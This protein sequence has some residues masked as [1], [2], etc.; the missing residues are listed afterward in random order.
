VTGLAAYGLRCEFLVTPLGI[1][2]PVPRLS[3][4]MRSE[5]RGDRPTA[6]RVTVTRLSAG[7]EPAEECLDSGWQ[8]AD[9][10]EA[11]YAGAPLRS[12]T[13]YAWHVRLR[14]GAGADGPAADSWFETGLLHPGEWQAQWI[15]RDPES[16]PPA[17]PPTDHDI[18]GDGLLGFLNRRLPPCGYLRRSFTLPA[19]PVRAR[20]LI[21]ARGLYEAR[22]NGQRA[23]DAELA[24]G[25]TDYR[26]RI[27]YQCYDVTGLLRA[28]PN[29]LGA[30]LGDGWYSGRVGPGAR[31]LGEHY[32]TR[33]ELLCQLHVDL[34]GGGPEVICSDGQWH[35]ATGP[36][37]SADL[38][39][40]ECYDARRELDGWDR[41]GYAAPGW[42]P[43]LV[44]GPDTA[45]LTASSDEPVRV[46][47][48]LAPRA[49][50]RQPDG[51]F[52]ADLGQNMVGRV[53]L[54]IRGARRGDR[55]VLRHGEMLAAD[56]RLYTANLRLAAATDT[57]I[58]AG[59]DA[60][61]FEP[62]FTV[63]GFRYVEITGCRAAPAPGDL[64]GLV[65]HSDVP[66]AGE[67]QTSDDTVNALLSNIWW[68]QRG[69]SVSVPTDCP[70]RDE[71]LGWLADAQ[72]FLPTA[73]RNADVAAFFARWMR[74]VI[75]SRLPGGAFPDVAP[76]LVFERT[77]APGWGDAGVIIPWT[78]WRTY[79]DRRVL[80]RS[81]DAMAGW[82]DYVHA[83]NPDLIWRHRTGNHYGDWLQAGAQTPREVLATAYFARSAGL[84]ASAAQVLGRDEQARQYGHLAARITA[85]F[86]A[87][88]VFPD[89][90][91]AGETQTSYLL[92]LGFGLL[93]PELADAAAARLAAD[94]EAR[95]FR[96]TTGF[97]G[98]ALLCPVLT[99]HGRADL[100]YALLHQDGYPSWNYSIRHGATTIWERWDG[101]TDER[102]F[103][104]VAMNSFNHY[105]L[106]SVGDWLF[107]SAG[108]IGQAA[109]SAG[110]REVV[111]SP[112]PGGR[113]TWARAWQETPR[114]RITCAWRIADGQ[115]GLQVSIPPGATARVRVPTADPATVREGGVPVA[116]APGL[117]VAGTSDR[118][119][120]C[121][122]GSGSYE[123]TAAW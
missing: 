2:E 26:A 50:T 42:A 4:R 57:D 110:Y 106:G 120:L 23:G 62:R 81:F 43:V 103:Q 63:H 117:T 108:G 72:V 37:R 80:Q 61:T 39:A 6:R 97:L 19:A 12:R 60:E 65:L 100:A 93:P 58:A 46:T 107:G 114:G 74:D 29:V 89:G 22:L 14:D 47:Q 98:V 30:I 99:E 11:E 51:T 122:T 48:E 91:V 59:R 88:F 52:L 7:G 20:L 41:P 79:G 64:A 35:A 92:A 18:P 95:G 104:S 105:S 118:A 40:G 109:S 78:L 111:L 15:A 34:P 5:R 90:R 73:S 31:R 25:W 86:N 119:V 85:A 10:P 113:L 115:L 16:A 102:G 66:R 1:G 8:D 33:P 76:R 75:S 121:D 13:R 87:E 112:R 70:Q 101:W 82:V 53:R 3:W 83:A 17:D 116:R 24:P 69:N 44:T 28:G 54:T 123:F 84:V 68:S 21:T 96:L 55:I 49:V 77:G 38:L 71:R 9:L 56:G 45:L 27:Q 67:L 94:I 36:L 32:G